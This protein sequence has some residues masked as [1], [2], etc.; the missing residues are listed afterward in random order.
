MDALLAESNKAAK[1][2][3]KGRL[4]SE[5]YSQSGYGTCVSEAEDSEAFYSD[6]EEELQFETEGETIDDYEWKEPII[7]SATPS[8]PSQALESKGRGSRLFKQKQERMNK[9]TKSGQG[10]L[11][12]LPTGRITDRQRCGYVA[13]TK[14]DKPADLD[15]PSGTGA[16]PK[17]TTIADMQKND[18]TF[19]DFT[20]PKPQKITV[21]RVVIEKPQ[22]DL[23]FNFMRPNQ[24]NGHAGAF[25]ALAMERPA[26]ACGQSDER[27]KPWSAYGGSF[28]SVRAPVKNMNFGAINPVKNTPDVAKDFGSQI[29]EI[30]TSNYKKM[31]KLSIR[32]T[33]NLPPG[34][35]SK[36]WENATALGFKKP[37]IGNVEVPGRKMSMRDL[38][39]DKNASLPP[40]PSPV[41]PTPVEPLKPILH[42]SQSAQYLS[43]NWD[44]EERCPTRAGPVPPT[45]FVS[46]KCNLE[47]S[48]KSKGGLIYEPSFRMVCPSPSNKMF[49]PKRF[50]KAVNQAVWTP[51]C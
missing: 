2:F 21:D 3:A 8:G 39:V 17:L 19:I 29:N 50:D 43:W 6:S 48:T 45:N 18:P 41:P 36:H 46:K 49:Q 31:G 25:G 47:K 38:L 28:S 26:S 4:R 5:K 37:A 22:G 15:D 35:P 16:K 7:R 13:R 11:S 42:D 1:L 24:F 40:S 30:A 20:M 51:G 34:L 9:F 12:G 10:K 23:P 27:E 33:K 14:Y 32:K 44:K